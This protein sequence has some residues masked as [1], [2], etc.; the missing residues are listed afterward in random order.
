MGTAFGLVEEALREVF[1]PYLFRGL[2]EGLTTRANNRLP[3][4]QVG[5]AIPDPVQ[6][7]PENWTASCVIT[8]HLVSALRGQTTFRTADHTACLRGGW[9][10]V[11]HRGEQRAEAALTAALEGP[12]VQQARHMRRA[13]KTGA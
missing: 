8:G 2:M 7:A 1:L 10:A 13:A 9:L 11:R 3:V 6:T 12:P 4:K 5:M